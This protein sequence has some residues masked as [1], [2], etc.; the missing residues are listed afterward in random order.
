MKMLTVNRK[1][2]FLFMLAPLIASAQNNSELCDDIASFACA[3]GEYNDGTGVASNR[4]FDTESPSAELT[5][6]VSGKL[7]SRFSKLIENPSNSYFRQTAITG[8]SLTAAPECASN[9]SSEVKKCNEVIVQGLIVLARSS[10]IGSAGSSSKGGSTPS[11]QQ[12]KNNL[13]K[14]TMIIRNQQFASVVESVVAEADKKT[15]DPATEKK[16]RE[17]MIPQLKVML[18]DK[19]RSLPIDPEKRDFMVAKI[20]SITFAGTDC[21]EKSDGI[22]RHFIPNAFY[23]PNQNILK[24]CR[25]LLQQNVSEFH[26]ASVLLHELAHSIDPCCLAKGAGEAI[27][28]HRDT[29]N[30]QLMDSEYV[31]PDLVS[32]LR[33]SKSV[34]AKNSVTVYPGTGG[35]FGPPPEFDHCKDQIGESTSDWF[36]SEVLVD[37]IQ[38]AHPR[39]TTEQWR[40]GASNIFRPICNFQEPKG[41]DD[42]PHLFERLNA[43]FLQN[44]KLR[45]KMKCTSG[46][47]ARVYCDATPA[48]ANRPPQLP[49]LGF[50]GGFGQ[51]G[52]NY[53]QPPGAPAPTS[54]MPSGSGRVSQ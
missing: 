36:A 28:K 46:N 10:A 29:T 25:G 6:E 53:P 2:V 5:T 7:R 3:P 11:H 23:S 19:L 54:P 17:R 9:S 24:I 47:P 37:Y 14:I 38:K 44:P 42:H 27:I 30:L 48:T 43:I 16:I 8:L 18:A 40:M 41:F 20:Q 50:G 34:A 26:V 31:L 21:G 13:E 15:E 1:L 51:P 39:L 12:V 35:Q 49:A 4:M 32:C 45:Q 33:S 22:S 52:S